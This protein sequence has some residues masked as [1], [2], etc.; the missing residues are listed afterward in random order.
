MTMDSP[1]LRLARIRIYPLKGA[2]GLDLQG[3]APDLFGI[4]GDRRWMVVRP[5]GLFISQ[6]TH[7]SLALVRVEATGAGPSGA[8]FRVQAPDLPPL[9]LQE[10]DAGDEMM[11]V[12]LHQDRLRGR[13][14]EE[15]G[16]WFSDFFQEECRL[17]F[18]PPEVHRPVDQVFAPGHRASFSDGYPLLVTTEE[19]LHALNQLLP[20][21]S[22]MLSFRPNLVIRGSG[23]WEEDRWR[24]LEIGDARIDLVKPCARCSVIRVNQETGEVGREPLSTLSRVR[25]WEGKAYFGQNAVF[26]R[27][28]SFRVEQSV[29]I[30]EEG[31]PRPPLDASALSS[32]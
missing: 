18:I 27:N 19:S 10:G 3:S 9:L 6:R 28:G 26:T 21:P 29:R 30:V 22:S 5:Q 13:V 14:L 20:Q 2:A 24:V 16:S 11:E 1:E 31:D 4:P 23:A 25:R 8:P 15:A 12:Q 17:V 32:T 7:P